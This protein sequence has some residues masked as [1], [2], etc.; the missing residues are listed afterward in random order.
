MV[1]SSFCISLETLSWRVESMEAKVL[2]LLELRGRFFG[3]IENADKAL[4][5]RR[6]KKSHARRNL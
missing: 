2:F 6:Q 4:P 1:P 3:N 5:D